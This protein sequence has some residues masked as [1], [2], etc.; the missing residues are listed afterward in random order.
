MNGHRT[1]EIFIK[2]FWYLSGKNNGVLEYF[3][4]YFAHMV[5]KP[6]EQPG[7]ALVVKGKQGIGK[8]ITLGYG[9]FGTY[10]QIALCWVKKSGTFWY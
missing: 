10:S 5:Q 8:N 1:C 7:T 3:L 6:G 2:Q 4:N 9:T